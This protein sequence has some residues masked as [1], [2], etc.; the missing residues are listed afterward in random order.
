[1]TFEEAGFDSD[2]TTYEVGF[3]RASVGRR[4]ADRWADTVDFRTDEAARRW[5]AARMRQ[6]AEEELATL[7][8]RIAVLEEVL[9]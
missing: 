2:V 4:G 3:T 7:R 5:A 8:A 6:L 1:M 9:G